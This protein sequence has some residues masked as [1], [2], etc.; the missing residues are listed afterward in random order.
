MLHE[1]PAI[2]QTLPDFRCTE[3]SLLAVNKVQG[4]TIVSDLLLL[5]VSCLYISVTKGVNI[6]FFSADEGR[7]R[8]AQ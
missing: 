4:E 2:I 8:E 7:N 1:V 3:E 5:S 6:Y